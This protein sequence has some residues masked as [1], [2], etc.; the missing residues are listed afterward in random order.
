MK[1]LIS[2]SLIAVFIFTTTNALAYEHNTTSTGAVLYWD[3]CL[4]VHINEKI[5]DYLTKEQ[6]WNQVQTAIDNWNASPDANIQLT[7]AGWTNAEV[8][9][10]DGGYNANVIIIRH[11]PGSW[12][13]G[14]KLGNAS[15]R[16]NSETGQ[17]WGCDVEVNG[18]AHGIS[19]NGRPSGM[20][21]DLQSTVL[22]ELGHCLGLAH[23]NVPG[24]VMEEQ[25]ILGDVRQA[26]TQDDINGVESNHP[27]ESEDNGVSCFGTDPGYHDS[28]AP[29]PDQDFREDEPACSV[30]ALR[31][32]SGIRLHPFIFL[33]FG[34]LIIR[35]LKD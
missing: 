1:K 11:E 12:S 16:F 26:L 33:L 7:L 30:T 9:H 32:K 31:S 2:I 27:L 20:E 23:S 29:P 35:R 13:H 5:P 8:G 19:I 18:V 15:T 21:I 4:Q 6:V 22:H 10:D 17:M 25:I 28:N 24:S 34:F 14:R 3:T